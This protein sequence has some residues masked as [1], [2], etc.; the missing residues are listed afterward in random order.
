MATQ[1]VRD[2]RIIRK[3]GQGGMGQVWLAQHIHLD[4]QVA[5]KILS[6]EWRADPRFLEQLRNEAQLQASLEHPNIIPVRDFFVENGQPFM[7][8]NFFPGTSLERLIAQRGA[9][10]SAVALRII[11]PVLEALNHAHLRGILHRDIKPGNILVTPQ[12]DVRVTDFGLAR[13]LVRKRHPNAPKL[14]GTPQYMS[15]EAIQNPTGTDHLAD[16]YAAGMVLYEMLTGT[17]P[18]DGDSVEVI[19]NQQVTQPVPDPGRTHSNVDP[20]LSGIV[21]TALEKDPSNR[22]AGCGQFLEYI[23]HYLEEPQETQPQVAE[24]TFDY[25]S[26]RDESRYV[27]PNQGPPVP[28]ADAAAERPVRS[29]APHPEPAT[30]REAPP[31]GP[32]EPQ[33]P[34]L[35][36]WILAWPWRRWHHALTHL[37]WLQYAILVLIAALAVTSPIGRLFSSSWSLVP[38][39]GRPLQSIFLYGI[40]AQVWPQLFGFSLF[41]GYAWLLRFRA[42]QPTD[43]PNA[44]MAWF[45]MFPATAVAIGL[46]W[47]VALPGWLAWL[48]RAGAVTLMQDGGL[49]HAGDGVLAICAALWYLILAATFAGAAVMGEMLWSHYVPKH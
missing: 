47:F 33:P 48:M 40:P 3:I 18:F 39:A 31:P 35:I 28:R 19:C 21:M 32:P 11:R 5:I 25:R 22:F 20:A 9:F 14:F 24:P 44:A 43:H 10:P 38:L 46:L 13:A 2:Y 1:Q 42:H 41:A 26:T 6:P 45:L 29:G 23:D 49:A 36:A 27:S 7:V 34:A 16:V 17:L 37:P 30:H 15:P 8:S 4:R 12:W